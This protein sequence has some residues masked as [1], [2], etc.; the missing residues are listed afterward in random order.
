MSNLKTYYG[1]SFVATVRH[2]DGCGNGHNTFSVTGE[3]PGGGGACHDLI[4]QH[5]PKLEPII[6]FHLCSE[7]G[8][9]HYIANTAY[10]VNEGRLDYA[11]Q[12]AIWPDASD[13]DLTALGLAERL[14]ARLPALL[15][16]FRAAVEGLGLE[17]GRLVS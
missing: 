12:T 14:Q 6:K 3:Y 17:Y 4:V 10:W 9:L 16:D 15:Q 11:R 8:P 2:D 7:D 5:F 13:E 1:E